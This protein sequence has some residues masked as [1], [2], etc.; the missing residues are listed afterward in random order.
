MTKH[1]PAL[2]QAIVARAGAEVGEAV[3][4][5]LATECA[6]EARKARR[7]DDRMNCFV[8]TFDGSYICLNVAMSE[9]VSAVKELVH[10]KCGVEP[11]QQRLTYV[12]P[13]RCSCIASPQ[14]FVAATVSPR[15]PPQTASRP[16]FSAPTPTYSTIP[17]P[18][19][20]HIVMAG[21]NCIHHGLLM[22]TTFK[23]TPR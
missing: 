12:E 16:P 2:T 23:R 18:I 9:G 22:N 7:L 8:K 11:Y 6:S 17:P 19:G 21:A 14:H 10:A 4:H 5:V 20:L 1:T 13:P 15:P 3:P